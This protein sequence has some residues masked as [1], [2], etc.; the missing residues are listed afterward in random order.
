MEYLKTRDI[1]H[2]KWLLGHSRLEN[3]MKY[4]HCANAILTEVGSFTSKVAHS[5]EEACALV[6]SG[7]DFVCDM[8]GLKI[9]RKRK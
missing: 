8:N 3:T 5:L 6:E 9:F 2:C 1:F 4:I 7:F